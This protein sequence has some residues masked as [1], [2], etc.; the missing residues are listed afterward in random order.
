MSTGHVQSWLQRHDTFEII[1][2]L[3]SY[4]LYCW[5]LVTGLSIYIYIKKEREREI[6]YSL[7]AMFASLF[8]VFVSYSFV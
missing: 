3:Y 7:F 1:Q 5:L 2:G 8:H 6:L 4:Y